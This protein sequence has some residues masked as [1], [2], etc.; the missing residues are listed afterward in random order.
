MLPLFKNSMSGFGLDLLWTRLAEQNLGKSAVFD[1]LPVRHTRPVGIH[2]A[3]AMLKS[4]RRPKRNTASWRC[5]MV[6][7]SSFPC[8]TGPSTTQAG[9]GDR[10]P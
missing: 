4:G 6:S 9:A 3:A 2:L 10:D 1:A 5:D 8:L 7:A